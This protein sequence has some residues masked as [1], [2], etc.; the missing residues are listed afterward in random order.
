VGAVPGMAGPCRPHEPPGGVASL[1]GPHFHSPVFNNEQGLGPMPR[2]AASHRRAEEMSGERAAL[3]AAR[4]AS[5][6]PNSAPSSPCIFSPRRSLRASQVGAVRVGSA[7]NATARRPSPPPY[8]LDAEPTQSPPPVQP[9][10]AQPSASETASR[11]AAAPVPD[12]KPDVVTT[13]VEQLDNWRSFRQQHQEDLAQMA[14][15]AR[16]TRSGDAAAPS[17]E[18][19]ANAEPLMVL[20]S[21]SPETYMPERRRDV[22]CPVR[23]GPNT[24]LAVRSVKA[25]RAI[26]PVTT[27]VPQPRAPVQRRVSNGQRPLREFKPLPRKTERTAG[28]RL[29][30]SPISS[31]V[32]DSP[33]TNC[34]SP[35]SPGSGA[36]G[37]TAA[38]PVPWQKWRTNG[39]WR[40]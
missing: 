29:L 34:R 33:G 23:A 25:G 12:A 4:P 39:E 26:H 16:A 8:A 31:R 30:E 21:A 15:A 36:T 10:G 3:L 28:E 24:D 13:A 38:S 2:S 6:P 11:G 19:N 17:E 18:Y 14:D 35:G 1:G 37:S 40:V 9:L 5:H 22:A 20:G 32:T 7:N 27:R